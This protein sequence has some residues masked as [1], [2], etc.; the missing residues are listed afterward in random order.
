MNEIQPNSIDPNFPD[1]ISMLRHRADQRPEK[2][3]FT[4]LVD[5]DDQE[6]PWTFAE[7][8]RQARTI[9][10]ALQAQGFTGERAILIYPPGLEYV[11]GFLGC[12]YAGVVAVPAY[13]PDP[14]RLER[15]LPRLLGIVRDSQSKVL[16]TTETIKNLAEFMASQEPDLKK[17]TWIS[18]DSLDSDLA[19]KWKDPG[20]K[21][22]TLAFLQY[23]SGSTGDPKGVMLSHRNLLANMELIRQG[24]GLKTDQDRGVV[25]L[26]PYHDMG[27]I[28]GILESLY[29]AGHSILMSPLHFL[30]RPLRWLKA[31]SKYQGTVSGGPNFAYEMCVRK[32]KPEVLPD[33]DLSHWQVAFSGAEPILPHT[34]DRFVEVFGPYGFD[35]KA[36]YPCYGLAEATLMVSGSRRGLGWT[37]K[38]VDKREYQKNAVSEVQDSSDGSHWEIVACG[39]GMPGQVVRVVRPDTLH[40]CEDGEIGEILVHGPS[41][42]QGYYQKPDLTREVFQLNLADTPG[43]TFLRTGDLGFLDGEQLFVTGRLKDLIIIRGQNHYP[44][45]IERTVETSHDI[46]RKGCVAAFSIKADFEEHLVVVAEADLDR[47]ENPELQLPTI[48]REVRKAVASHHDLDPHSVVLIKKGSLPKT[49]SG[50]IRRQSTREEYLAGKLIVVHRFDFH[51]LHSKSAESQPSQ[52]NG[53]GGA[54]NQDEAHIQ[55]WLIDRLSDHL[56]VEPATIDPAQALSEF[57]LDSKDAVNLSGDLEDWLG[58]KLSP[59]L[60]WK[61]PTIQKLSHYLASEGSPAGTPS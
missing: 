36:I 55:A 33:L 11:A 38:K 54:S 30:Q 35:P 4:M 3:A 34:L 47:M 39:T 61:Y 40:P 28:G 31:I 13:P 2:V 15:T 10:A 45:D 5:G 16:L 41:V 26:P 23:T 37:S 42:A 20:V 22:E 56:E 57:G 27:L 49:S 21:P 59:T 6:I 12:L 8:D 14:S 53:A 43:A 58:R 51:G 24:F 25:W 18:T 48:E 1:L 32:F 46:F 44:Q 50:K 9:A 7:V 60:L 17:L 52:P 19:A 29:V